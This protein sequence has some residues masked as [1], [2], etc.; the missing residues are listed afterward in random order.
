MEHGGPGDDGTGC[1]L[2]S[3]HVACCAAAAN[4]VKQIVKDTTRA[5]L[6]DQEVNGI[7]E[8]VDE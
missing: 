1:I 8:A 3:W 7:N 5:I 4:R 6:L 2:V